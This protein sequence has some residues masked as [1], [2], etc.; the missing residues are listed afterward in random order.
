MSLT[1]ETRSIKWYETCKWIC[2]LNEIICSNKQRWNK[3]KCR[4]EFKEL[5]DKWVFDKGFIFNPSNCKCECDKS[6]NTGQYLDYSDCK[7][8]K[9][10]I[11]PLIEKCTKNDDDKT[12]IVNTIVKNDDKTKIVKTTVENKNSSCKVY[13]ISMTISFTILTVITI[14]FIYYNWFLIKNKG[15]CGKSNTQKE[16]LIWRQNI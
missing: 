14:Y 7:C 3:D 8:T 6:C 10:L 11:D 16:I 5:I 12:K 15:F 2:R 13:I 1:N 4:C 9:N